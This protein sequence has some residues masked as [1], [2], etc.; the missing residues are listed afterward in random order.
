[1]KGVSAEDL[2]RSVNFVEPSLIRVEADEA[3][4]NLHIMIRYEIEKKLISGEIEVDDLPDA[5][6]D[7]YEE[8][9]GIRSPNRTLG[10]LQDIHW[11]FGAFGYF[12]T[13]TRGNLYSAQL[14]T[15]ARKELPDHDEQIRRGEFTPLLEWMRK[16]VHSRGSIIE[17]SELIK[18]ATGNYP[19]PDDFVKYLQDKVE[20][21][22]EL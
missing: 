8:F 14:L 19:S 11:S 3:T 6:D 17:P 9:L 21:L 13:D 16:N 20:F 22:Y 1:M 2:W 5:W 10:V 12:P 15:A 7:M 4:Y 18:E